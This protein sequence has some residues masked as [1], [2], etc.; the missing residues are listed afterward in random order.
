MRGILTGAFVFLATIQAN[1]QSTIPTPFLGKTVKIKFVEDRD[2]RI[3]NETTEFSH[4]KAAIELDTVIGPTG[5]ITSVWTADTT[6]NQGK[7]VP[8]RN[9]Q[10]RLGRGRTTTITSNEI[11]I[12]DAQNGGAR[13]FRVKLDPSYSGCKVK[14]RYERKSEQWL[15]TGIMDKKAFE[16][17]NHRASDVT[18]SV[19]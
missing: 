19:N 14:I 13:H 3:I 5:K 2:Q 8:Q 16:M 18:C 17:R 15:S 11:R 6:D 9:V 10:G 1:A 12:V 4:W 7:I